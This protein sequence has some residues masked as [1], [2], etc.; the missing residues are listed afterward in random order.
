[1]QNVT[2][3]MD[4]ANPARA[5]AAVRIWSPSARAIRGP[6]GESIAEVLSAAFSSREWTRAPMPVGDRSDPHSA[7][8]I[9]AQWEDAP[10][11]LLASEDTPG[12]PLEDRRVL[13][14]VVG[15]VLDAERIDAYRLGPF[16][17]REGDGLLAYIGVAPCAQ[18]LRLRV[19]GSRR[20]QHIVRRTAGRGAPGSSGVVQKSS[21]LSEALRRRW[22]RRAPSAGSSPPASART[23]ICRDTRTSKATERLTTSNAAAPRIMT[24]LSA[25]HH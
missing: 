21:P 3:D 12:V 19:G 1:M 9:L 7:R 13:G 25:S 10:Q 6:L 8:G 22:R 16:G 24:N 18:G 2:R 14:C 23:S 5:A 4:Q 17:A 11:V 15:G 20:G